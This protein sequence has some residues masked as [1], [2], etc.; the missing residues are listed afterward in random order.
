[1]S[2]YEELKSRSEKQMFSQPA[3]ADKPGRGRKADT[4]VETLVKSTTRAIGSSLGRQIVRGVLG[5][6]FGGK[7][8][9]R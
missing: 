4:I 1:T 6:L 9:R 2:A 7:K 3:V 5:S 8:R